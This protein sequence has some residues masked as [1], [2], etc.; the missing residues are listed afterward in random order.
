[1][2]ELLPTRYELLRRSFDDLRYGQLSSYPLIGLGSLS[3]FDGSRVPAGCATMHAWDYVPYERADGRSLGRD[4]GGVRPA[5]AHPHGPL[6]AQP[7]A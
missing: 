1:M 6:P 4:E 7:D 3:E 5:H 2:T